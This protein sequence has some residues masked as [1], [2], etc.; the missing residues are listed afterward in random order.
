MKHHLILTIIACGA[1]LA[2]CPGLRAQ[3]SSPSPSP[4]GLSH[5]RF[6]ERGDG[7][8][9]LER[10]TKALGLTAEQRSQIKPIVEG[11]AAQI[12]AN[13]R[14]KGLSVQEKIAK[15]KG[16]RENAASQINAL[17]TPDQQAKFTELK[18]RIRER[19]EGEATGQ[20]SPA[21]SATP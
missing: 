2:P 10:L 11:A 8:L 16:V 17:L 14:E 18:Q 21:P 9:T 1:C 20:V 13:W 15:N 7:L 3:D 19:R 12:R 6:R 4:S 5:G